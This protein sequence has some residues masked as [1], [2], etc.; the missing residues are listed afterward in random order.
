VSTPIVITTE[1]AQPDASVLCDDGT[2]A[3]LEVYANGRLFTWAC[4]ACLPNVPG[5]SSPLAADDVIPGHW[6]VR[7]PDG[8]LRGFYGGASADQVR[9]HFGD[10]GHQ[11]TINPTTARVLYGIAA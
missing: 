4:T 11:L 9:S 3:T 5:Y 7:N 6:T 10:Q 8:T 1:R 2:P